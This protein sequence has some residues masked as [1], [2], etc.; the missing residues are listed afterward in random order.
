MNNLDDLMDPAYGDADGDK[1]QVDGTQFS[2]SEATKKSE[3]EQP[4]V[5]MGRPTV[6]I[7]NPQN[8]NGILETLTLDQ[9]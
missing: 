9:A 7:L 2:L 6:D 4:E 3:Q 8:N 1:K 5:P